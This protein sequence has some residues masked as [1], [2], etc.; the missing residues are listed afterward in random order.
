MSKA[1]DNGEVAE[2]TELGNWGT[3]EVT[4]VMEMFAWR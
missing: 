1:N 4:Q 3:G 2:L